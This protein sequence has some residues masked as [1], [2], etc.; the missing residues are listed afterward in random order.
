MYILHLFDELLAEGA[1]GSKGLSL[2]RHVLLGLGVE[3]GVLHEAV[4]KHPQVAL[5]VERFEIHAALVL[6]LGC[7]Q[8]FGHY[9]IHYVVHVSTSLELYTW[10]CTCFNER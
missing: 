1:G 9:L 5:D 7:L 4:D 3:G 10:M 6:L 8:Q 2:E